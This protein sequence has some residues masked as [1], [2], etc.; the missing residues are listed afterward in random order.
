M[1]SENE[2]E[3]EVESTDWIA[4]VEARGGWIPS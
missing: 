1:A 2:K 4:E 3:V